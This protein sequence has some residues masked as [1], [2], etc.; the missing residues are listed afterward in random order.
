M[1][2]IRIIGPAGSREL[3]GLADSGADD[4]LLPES[5]IERLGVIIRPDDRAAIAGIT[6]EA[7]VA[8]Y[9]TVA[10]EL[11]RGGRPYRWSA[12]VGFYGRAKVVLGHADFLDHFTATFNGRQRHLTL[13]PNGTAPPAS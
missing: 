5:L 12:Q 4:I 7:T 9:G 10:L 1:V 3:V 13:Q 8:R 6:G 11:A 2:P